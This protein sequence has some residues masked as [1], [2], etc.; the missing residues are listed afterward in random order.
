MIKPIYALLLSVMLI[1]HTSLHA[2]TA[3][4]TGNYVFPVQLQSSGNIYYQAAHHDYPATDI[5]CPP[6]SLFRAVTDGIVDH[7][8][9]Q[10][11]WAQ[12]IN[13]PETRG[14]ISVSI[15]GDDGIR[16]YGSHLSDIA[17]NLTVGQRVTVGQTLGY[18]GDTG[19][20]RVTPPHLHFGI[21]R[22]TT[23]DDWATRRGEIS[24]YPY[25]QAWER[26]EALAPSI[27]PLP[28][29]GDPKGEAL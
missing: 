16:Y 6:G 25:L 10:D 9:T 14:G 28:N 3:P 29:E 2:D 17:T 24:P 20:A 19:N 13:A 22:P 23:P 12:T 4:I 21:S 26:G 27:A 11:V 8:S 18:T 15:V 5:F 1:S 7:I